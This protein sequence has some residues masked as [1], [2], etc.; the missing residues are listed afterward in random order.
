MYKLT[1]LLQLL[2]ID[3]N[4]KI[5]SGIL[6]IKI[7]VNNDNILIIITITTIIFSIAIIIRLD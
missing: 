2:Y 3:E 1:N 4:G 7:S 5:I 6:I